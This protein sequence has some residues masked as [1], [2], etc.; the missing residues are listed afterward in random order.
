MHILMCFGTLPGVGS[1]GDQVN[2][3]SWHPDL[4]TI[5]YYIATTAPPLLETSLPQNACLHYD[6]AV[7]SLVTLS[8][9]SHNRLLERNLSPTRKAIGMAI[10][11]YYT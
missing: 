4:A 2:V 9:Y 3:N 7:F 11:I 10:G 8:L 1:V 6:S 5:H